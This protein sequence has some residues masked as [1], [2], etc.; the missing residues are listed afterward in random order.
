M[1]MSPVRLLLISGLLVAAL[2]LCAGCTQSAPATTTTAPAVTTAD[3]TAPAAS[4]L[5]AKKVRLETTM[6]NITIAL[7]PNMPVTTGNFGTLVQKGYY[8]GVIFHRV[9]DGFMIQGGDPTGTGRGGP[10]YVIPDEFTGTNRN[11]RGTVAMANAG[12]NTGGSQ[13]FINLVDNNYLDSKHPVFGH[14]TDG[15]D[16]VDA[17][18]KVPTDAN[19]RPLRNVTIIRAVMA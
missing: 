3:T 8:D 2:V 15:M 10:G 7:D 12:P 4:A 19:G 13:F 11:N 5:A 16:V 9:I 6:G 1:S 17:I 18:G 14:V